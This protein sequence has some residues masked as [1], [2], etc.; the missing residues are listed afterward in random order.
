[1]NKIEKA[2]K[3]V[4]TFSDAVNSGLDNKEFA[5]AMMNEHRTLQQL[6]FGSIVSAIKSWSD[7]YESGRYDARNEQ[8]CKICNKIWNLLKDEMYLPLI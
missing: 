3:V 2:K 5:Q 1:M 8:T 6:M 7:M 4:E